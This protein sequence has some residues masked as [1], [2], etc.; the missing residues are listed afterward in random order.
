[1]V[2]PLEEPPDGE[3]HCPGC[4]PVG[5]VHMS[6]VHDQDH[7]VQHDPVDIETSTFSDPQSPV[8]S[9]S[10]RKG[11]KKVNGRGRGRKLKVP[12]GS[13]TEEV[14]EVD[15][16]PIAPSKA[17]GRPRKSAVRPRP[18]PASSDEEEVV[19]FSVRPG[20]RSRPLQQRITAPINLPRVRLRLPGQ[21]GKGKERE[22]EESPHGLFDDILSPDERDTT[23]SLITNTDKL[24]FERSRIA[25][26]VSSF[27]D[28]FYRKCC[29]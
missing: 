28:A 4:P 8:P 9:A 27:G 12:D 23:K 25:A 20:K 21:R 26:E 2:P 16:T 24:F 11:R 29:D 5:E 3:W 14:V 15:D 19:T 18:T 17:R 13:D 6:D 1:M 7:D 22:E 10:I